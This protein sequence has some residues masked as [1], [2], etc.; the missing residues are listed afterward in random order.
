MKEDKK[1]LE[2]LKRLRKELKETHELTIDFL[3]NIF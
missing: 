3:K 2:A 1:L